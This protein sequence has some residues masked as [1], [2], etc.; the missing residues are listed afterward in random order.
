MPCNSR[1][2]T[3]A[4]TARHLLPLRREKEL[5]LFNSNFSAVA[6]QASLLAGFSMAFLE[7]SVHLNSDDHH[8][9]P[10]GLLH[11]FATVPTMRRPLP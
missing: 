2:L 11:V 7:M 8:D 6:T 10:R 4:P 9:L 3:A 1:S 5:N